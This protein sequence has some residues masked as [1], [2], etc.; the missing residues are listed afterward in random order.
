MSLMKRVVKFGIVLF[1]LDFIGLG[2]GVG[3]FMEGLGDM[4]GDFMGFVL[5]VGVVLE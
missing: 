2:L 5:G 3:E 1:V 4:D